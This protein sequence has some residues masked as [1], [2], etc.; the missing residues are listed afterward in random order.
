MVANQWVAEK[1]G[2]L[3]DTTWHLVSSMHYLVLATR[4]SLLATR[5]SLLTTHQG[6]RPGRHGQQLTLTL[7]SPQPYS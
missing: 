4:Y 5:Y 2:A 6:L 7:T 1:L 3:L